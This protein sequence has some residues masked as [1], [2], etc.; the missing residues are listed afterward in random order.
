[1]LFGLSKG[2]RRMVLSGI[3]IFFFLLLTLLFT[4][5]E[6]RQMLT[7]PLII[8]G[9]PQGFG[10]K[11]IFSLAV[12]FAV[13]LLP[14]YSLKSIKAKD[15]GDGQHGSARW[16]TEKEIDDHYL[17][18][19]HGHEKEAGFV[20]CF[21]TSGRKWLI[22]T[23]DQSLLLLAPP[24]AG[25]TTSVIVPTIYYN[26][27]VNRNTSGGG[28]S[29]IATDLKGELLRLCGGQLTKSG[30]RV[31]VLNLREP[32]ESLFF[33]LL[34]N[35]NRNM[36]VYLKGTSEK[37]RLISYGKA[38]R[39]AKILAQ[40]IVHNLD[41]STT[42]DTAAYFNETAQGL[43]TGIILLVSQYACKQEQR[44]IISVFNLIIDL[45]GVSAEGQSASNTAVQRNKLHE[46]LEHIDNDRI[47]SH[48][49]AVMSADI[50]SSM[51][52]FS[53]ALGKLVGLIDA[54]LEQMISRHSTE[55]NDLDFIKNPT[56]IFIICPEE[57]PT[58][59]FFGSLFLRYFL[60]DL[61]AQARTSPKGAL[62]RKVLC[63]WDEFGNMPAIK[64][65]DVLFSAARSAGIRIMPTLQS[66]AQLQKS[67]NQNTAKIIRETCQ[68]T[69][70]TYVAPM[71]RETAEEISKVLG[72]RT[73]Q[74]GSISA[75]RG[76]SR[77]TQMMGKPL[78]TSDEIMGMGI[79]NFICMKSGCR[80]MQTKLPYYKDY[81]R[82]CEDYTIAIRNDVVAIERMT[83]E[84]VKNLSRSVCRLRVGMFG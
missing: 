58:R 10:I 3:G 13:S 60:N 33:N 23:S 16:A 36:D 5:I 31:A 82:K 26:A 70:T 37:E 79:G 11:V 55:L 83:E 17:W 20:V 4:A 9:I 12:T 69:L 40:S 38:E 61:I 80:P 34:N 51:N 73:V 45:N 27:A 67:Y 44:H 43:L 39:Y 62:Q 30:Y 75:G 41:V 49:G 35:V 18:V 19:K 28:A 84:D 7:L 54:E 64:D 25:K 77:T 1:M 8:K 53:S 57:N 74:S 66:L 71:A 63:L 42:N 6:T 48:V 65:V 21:D 47:K 76:G 14:S 50:R 81:L 56:A 29:I 22:D 24:G 72:N 2:E 15:V 78:M 32:F 52:I 59:Y 46:L 68:M